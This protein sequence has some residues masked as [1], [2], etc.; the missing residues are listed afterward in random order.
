MKVLIEGL[1]PDAV[2]L[3]R[4]LASEGDEVR[5]AGTTGAGDRE[6]LAALDLRELGVVVE[7]NADL[8]TDPGPADLAYLDVWTPETAARVQRLRAQGSRVSCLGDLLLERWAGATIGITGTAGK[9]STTRLTAEILLLAGIDVAVS[10][11][12]RAGNLW[13]TDDL[14]AAL[15]RGGTASRVLLLELTSSHL[16]FMHHSPGLAAVISFWPDHLELH[17]SLERYRAAKE[18]IVR[19]Q[20]PG[21]VVVVNADDASA[22]FASATPARRVEISL[23]RPVERGAFLDPALGVVLVEEGVETSLGHIE[24]SSAHPANVLAAAAIA[25]AAGAPASAV[26]EAVGTA[27]TPPWRAEP[28]GELAGVTVID[29]GMAATPAKTAALLS[30][31]PGHS[32]VL[33]AGGLADAGGGPVHSA[34]EE[35]EILDRACDEVARAARAVVVFGEAGPRL[36]RL[37]RPRGVE[38]VEVTDLAAAVTAAARLAPGAG[39][40]IFSPLFP[41]ALADRARFAELVDRCG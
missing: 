19:H 12:A 3:A 40:V 5:L 10:R 35:I 15:G 34:P 38:V 26:A 16:A 2:A 11:G 39:A 28:C 29:D 23:H 36:A 7:P 30:R 41:V 22:G 20:R 18:T 27:A 8:D 33:V 6:A 25:S 1:G 13:P 17:G 32:I 24:G 37:L 9:T 14:L 21:D 4:L 31:Q